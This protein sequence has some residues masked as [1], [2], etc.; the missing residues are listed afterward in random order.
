MDLQSLRGIVKVKVSLTDSNVLTIREY[1][2][3]AFLAAVDV[4]STLFINSCSS[5][6]RV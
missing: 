2:V 3:G 4:F 6:W 1:N 5:P